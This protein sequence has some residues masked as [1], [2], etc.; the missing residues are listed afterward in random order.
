MWKLHT[1]LSDREFDLTRIVKEHNE[2]EIIRKTFG[3]A[4]YSEHGLPLLLYLIRRNDFD[5]RTSLFANVNAG[6]DNVHRGMILGLL[7]GASCEEIDKDHELDQEI[8][9]YTRI[10]MSGSAI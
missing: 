7:V 9:N 1:E 6:G 8:K 4:C 5:F 2:E 3:T 10:A